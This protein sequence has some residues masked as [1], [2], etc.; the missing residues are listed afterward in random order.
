MQKNRN[1]AYYIV[2]F[3]IGLGLIALVALLEGGVST[4]RFH[5]GYAGAYWM[6]LPLPLGLVFNALAVR[7]F[8]R[9]SEQI[10]SQN[11]RFLRAGLACGALAQLGLF[12][13]TMLFSF[14][15][16]P[17]VL[18]GSAVF[19]LGALILMAFAAILRRG[20]A[21]WLSW[22]LMVLFTIFGLIRGLVYIITGNMG[23]IPG[24]LGSIA[25]RLSPPLSRLAFLAKDIAAGSSIDPL[26]FLLPIAYLI[27]LLLLLAAVSTEGGWL[28]RSLLAAGALLLLV[29]STGFSNHRVD[30]FTLQAFDNAMAL[31]DN[32]AIWPGFAMREIQFAV[33]DGKGEIYFQ[34]GAQPVYGPETI[35]V[36]AYTATLAEGKPTLHV[37][38]YEETRALQ[39][40]LAILRPEAAE[41][42]Y[43]SI[44][45]HE[46]FHGFQFTQLGD[47]LENDSLSQMQAY[48]GLGAAL[49]AMPAYNQAWDAELFAAYQFLEGEAALSPYLAARDAREAI[50][51]ANL[52]PEDFETYRQSQ[53]IMERI[54]GTARYVELL[55]LPGEPRTHGLYQRLQTGT[56]SSER[57]YTSGMARALILDQTAPAWKQS[58]SFLEDLNLE[59]PKN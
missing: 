18:L 20:T 22:V 45:T 50:E 57:Y 29:F 10:P 23:G 13:Y 52:S 46:A 36:L 9:S 32:D 6:L 5:I 3:L 24:T 33:R 48:E 35:D 53:A 15:N 14:S 34:D 47:P 58:Y 51:K 26:R 1:L 41:D 42:L 39:D 4:E 31:T 30:A 59:Q 40:P 19:M 55:S 49:N 27:V 21:R 8:P 12:A 37:L 43:V 11:T 17:R 2:S 7:Y 25:V 38:G 44:L 56:T 54:E 28:K 16:M